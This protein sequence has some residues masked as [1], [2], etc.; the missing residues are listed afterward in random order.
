MN[1]IYARQSLDKKDSISIETQIQLCRK[2]LGP[3]AEDARLYID[4][5]YSGKDTRRP[6]FQ[7]MMEDVRQGE[8][9]KVVVYRLDRLS[10]SLLDFGSMMEL[11]RQ[12]RVEFASTQERFDTDSAIGKAMLSIVMVF[13]QLERETIQQRVKDNYH[14]RHARGAYDTRAPFG[15]EKCRLKRE[16]KGISS[17]LPKPGEKEVL[18]ELF[19]AYAFSATS[20]GSLAKGLN[21]RGILSPEGAL[22]DASKLFRILSNPLYVKADAAVFTHYRKRGA[23]LTDPMEAYSGERGLVSYGNWD[24]RGRKFSQPEKL[25]L[26]LGL[27][28]GIVGSGCFLLCQQKLENRSQSENSGRGKH[29]YLIGLLKCGHCGKAMKLNHP[30]GG[31]GRV[32]FICSGASNYSCCREAPRVEQELTEAAVEARILDFF[33]ENGERIL[34]RPREDSPRLRLLREALLKRQEQI[35]QLLDVAAL[36][37]GP[38][39]RHIRERI[40][41]LDGEIRKLEGEIQNEKLESGR[42]EGRLKELSELWGGMS[43][44]QRRELCFILFSRIEILKTEIRLYWN[45]PKKK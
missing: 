45:A 40:E 19:Q 12:H 16:G 5:G 22:W 27:H 35:R 21:E 24:R 20:L 9:Q 26:S 8:I 15:Y 6:C 34:L 39:G 1:A 13:A 23:F 29:S 14:A 28:A 43:R 44:E 10:R 3:G 32:K 30:P 41:T 2:E 18:E 33:R 25:K 11:F 4:R 42:E 31:K 7:A 38:G 36:G 37:E 17:L